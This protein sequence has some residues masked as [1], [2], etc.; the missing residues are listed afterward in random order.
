MLKIIE[1]LA[2]LIITVML[3][4]TKDKTSCDIK[5]V[6]HP[7]FCRI[8]LLQNSVDYSLEFKDDLGRQEVIKDILEQKFLSAKKHLYNFAQE[9]D[10]LLENDEE[11]NIRI[12]HHKHLDKLVAQYTDIS[13]YN[14]S[15]DDEKTLEIVIRKFLQWHEPNVDWLREKLEDIETSK[16]YVNQKVKVASVL[17]HHCSLWAS[18]LQDAKLTLGSLNGEIS[19]KKYKGNEIK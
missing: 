2:E 10:E 4:L 3:K 12:L 5:L 9:C 16:Y 8:E 19:G 15:S 18:T 6:E 7:F 17:D 13:R 1:K 11:F 14:L